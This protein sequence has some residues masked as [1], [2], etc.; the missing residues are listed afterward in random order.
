MAFRPCWISVS[1]ALIVLALGSTQPTHAQIRSSSTPPRAAE[2]LFDPKLEELRRASVA[3]EARKPTTIRRRAE[4][5]CIVPDLPTFLDAVA[6]WDATHFFPVLF[7]DD[8]ELLLKFIRAYR[9]ARIV[10]FPRVPHP[11]ATDQL[12]ENAVRAVG[13]SWVAD[14]IPALKGDAFPA[15]TSAPGVV[16]SHPESATLAGAVALAAGRFQPLL[17]WEIAETANETLD[18]TRATA[19]AAAI[20]TLIAARATNY[21]FLGDDCDFVTLAGNWPYRLKPERSPAP[22]FHALDDLIGRDRLTNRRWAYTGRLMGSPAASAYQAMCSLFLQPDSATLFSAYTEVT[23]PWNDFDLGPAVKALAPFMHVTRIQ[24][25]EAARLA[26]WH[27]TFDPK[28]RAGLVLINSSGGPIWFNLPGGQLGQTADIPLSVPAA[29]AMVHSFSAEFPYDPKTL[30]A[31]WLANGAFLYYGAMDEPFLQAFRPPRLVAHLIAEHLPFAA[32]LRPTPDELFG[33]PW[34]MLFLGDPLYRLLPN[35]ERP[36]AITWDMLAAWPALPVPGR[37][38]NEMND[39]ERLTWAWRTALLQASDSKKHA[40]RKPSP[41]A[42][43]SPLEVVLL[44]IARAKLPPRRRP[45]LDAL[46][47]DTL[48]ESSRGDL[49]VERLGRIPANEVSADVQRWLETARVAELQ[50]RIA[51]RDWQGILNQWTA[52]VR[53]DAPDDLRSK[54]TARV[55]AFAGESRQLDRWAAQLDAMAKDR[56]NDSIIA[57][58][59]R[60]V[61]ALR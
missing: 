13:S 33:F 54:V 23:P 47:V 14:G 22:G 32:A 7:E 59:R 10:Y 2:S 29:V 20:E 51:A 40:D 26:G 12:W 9:P 48:T 6:A 8:T 36:P 11:I 24:G 21:Q 37:L 31:R 58:E 28:N 42:A 35:E 3:W 4:V 18:Q 43:S 53:S 57:E 16:I 61:D 27:G 1:A 44:G 5:V 38:I 50:R 30:A 34:R 49:L 39:D 25:A 15:G 60:R 56:P 19:L 55:A 41:A 52:L 46:L 45:I 17:R